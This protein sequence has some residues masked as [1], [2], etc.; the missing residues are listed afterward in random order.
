LGNNATDTIVGGAWR[1][2]L[3]RDHRLVAVGYNGVLL[4][5]NVL[6]GLAGLGQPYAAFIRGINV[7]IAT[8]GVALLS[9][10]NSRL[11]CD[12]PAFCLHVGR[13]S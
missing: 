5:A 2:H 11:C 7:V 10:N 4:I 13:Q 1:A 3:G 8:N 12:H 6:R 9:F